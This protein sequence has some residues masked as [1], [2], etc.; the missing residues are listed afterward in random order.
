MAA[1][2]ASLRI[3]LVGFSSE[4]IPARHFPIVHVA[5]QLSEA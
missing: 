2:T 3:G 4:R 5:H 1:F